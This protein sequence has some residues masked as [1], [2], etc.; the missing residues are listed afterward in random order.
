MDAERAWGG[1]LTG[2]SWNRFV[3]W[4]HTNYRLNVQGDYDEDAKLRRGFS[5]TKYFENETWDWIHTISSGCTKFVDP[6][7]D[8]N[9]RQ[10]NYLI[11]Q[12][13]L[14][15]KHYDTQGWTSPLLTAM[16]NNQPLPTTTGGTM[17]LPADPGKLSNYKV[18]DNLGSFGMK[19][20]DTMEEVWK[21]I[22]RT[23]TVEVTTHT[24]EDL[25]LSIRAG[26]MQ[27]KSSRRSR[28]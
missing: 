2:T 8:V 3:S 14:Y 18:I 28:L 9:Y 13:C 5:I 25:R 23:T 19:D 7:E 16:E 6:G 26:D 17:I 21:E 22:S 11:L 27:P 20:Y 4:W 15:Y 1:I 10:I 12:V 24:L